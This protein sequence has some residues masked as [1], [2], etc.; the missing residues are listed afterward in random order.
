MSFFA[1]FL[2]CSHTPLSYVCK[3]TKNGVMTT[4]KP[5]PPPTGFCPKGF[6]EHSDQCYKLVQ[7]SA[8]SWKDAKDKCKSFGQG[9]N[10]ASVHSQKENAFIASLLYQDDDTS[11]D[12]VWIGGTAK[13]GGGQ[14]FEWS[15]YTPF[16]MDNWAPN[17][18]DG[19]IK[20]ILICLLI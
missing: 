8:A 16:N 19:V 3:K 14:N 10:L 12:V 7:T 20:T 4:P 11:T 18:P 5:T 9:F 15:D 1:S 6:E 17:E 2:K 13:T